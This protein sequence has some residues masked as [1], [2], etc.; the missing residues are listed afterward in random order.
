MSSE[1]IQTLEAILSLGIAFFVCVYQ[2][3]GIKKMR[4]MQS[5]IRIMQKC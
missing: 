4:N 3:I 1:I 5:S 2:S